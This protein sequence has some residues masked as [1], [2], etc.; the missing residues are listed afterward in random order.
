MCELIADWLSST[1]YW[2]LFSLYVPRVGIRLNQMKDEKTTFSSRK[3]GHHNIRE[4]QSSERKS[5][6]TI[7][8][9]SRKK[10]RQT[11]RS[12]ADEKTKNLFEKKK[13]NETFFFLLFIDS[14]YSSE[15]TQKIST[16]FRVY[17]LAPKININIKKSCSFNYAW[18]KNKMIYIPF[19][20]FR[21]YHR[22]FI[23]QQQHIIKNQVRWAQQSLLLLLLC[24]IYN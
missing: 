22:R 4:K 20:S 10:I 8:I 5:S 15:T 13:K 12:C 1:C 6:A 18:W 19:K 9:Y 7:Y 3:L 2:R 23:Q 14:V 16:M 24:F 11:V 17:I 21:L